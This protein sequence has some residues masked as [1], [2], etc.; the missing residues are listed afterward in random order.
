[1]GVEGFLERQIDGHR[2]LLGEGFVNGGAP[3]DGFRQQLANT[4]ADTL[5][6]SGRQ[7]LILGSRE[8]YRNIAPVLLNTHRLPLGL[9]EDLSEFVLG[10]GGGDGG[11]GALQNG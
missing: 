8:H 11:H 1:M 5:G 3:A 9:V 7:T 6:I 4:W 2:R 10:V